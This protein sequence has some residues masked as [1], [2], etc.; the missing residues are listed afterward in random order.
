MTVKEI[1]Q[2][3][4]VSFP[5]YLTLSNYLKSNNISKS[6]II[7]NLVNNNS[8]FILKQQNLDP[9]SPFLITWHACPANS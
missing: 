5:L 3:S 1:I 7:G 9:I 8:I 2:N 6:I 4:Y